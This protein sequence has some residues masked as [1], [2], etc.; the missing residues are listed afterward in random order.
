MLLY[1]L[2]KKLKSKIMIL[3]ASHGRYVVEPQIFRIYSPFHIS[4][5]PIRVYLSYC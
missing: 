2:V 1:M 3:Q 5:L 4:Y